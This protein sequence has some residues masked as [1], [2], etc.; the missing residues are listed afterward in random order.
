MSNVQRLRLVGA[1]MAVAGVV[2]GAAFGYILARLGASYFPD[3]K[4]PGAVAVIV[5]AL[6]LLTAAV[7]ASMLPA[8]P[9]MDRRDRIINPPH[10]F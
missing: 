1:V 2:A 3:M 8:L 6:V 5:A 10:T 7:V 4:M 9:W